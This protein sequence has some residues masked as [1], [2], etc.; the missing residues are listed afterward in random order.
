M[1][2]VDN[3]LGKEFSQGKRVEVSPG[4]SLIIYVSNFQHCIQH[5]F[6][7]R[8]EQTIYLFNSTEERA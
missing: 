3:Y 5:G 2:H 7:C 1:Q 6:R 8:N 4:F